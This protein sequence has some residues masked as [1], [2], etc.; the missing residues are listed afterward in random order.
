MGSL[1]VESK[2]E[3]ATND[4]KKIELNRRIAPTISTV[5]Q[6]Q[7]CFNRIRRAPAEGCPRGS[8]PVSA[9]KWFLRGLR[10]ED[11]SQAC[12]VVRAALVPHPAVS[13]QAP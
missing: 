5:V 10:E 13:Y 2:D 8:H 12:V 4:G 9:G 7:R 6:P 3:Q 11:A 1:A